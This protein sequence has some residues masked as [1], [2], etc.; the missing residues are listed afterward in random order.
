MEDAFTSLKM[1]MHAS[2]FSGFTRMVTTRA[3]TAFLLFL[4]PRTLGG[5]GEPPQA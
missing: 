1:E 5:E 4:D 2:I 3:N